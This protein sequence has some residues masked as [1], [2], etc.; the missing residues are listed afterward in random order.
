MLEGDR[1]QV[2]IPVV[3]R[4]AK[5]EEKD[6]TKT[7]DK[8]KYAFKDVEPGSYKVAA[9]KMPISPRAMSRSSSMKAR[10]RRAW[11]SN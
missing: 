6:K 7:D 5:G 11:I 9:T 4:D 2:G 3:L 8:G 10:T 1:P